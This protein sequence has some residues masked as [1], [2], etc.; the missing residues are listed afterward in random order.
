MEELPLEMESGRLRATKNGTDDPA[1]LT[2][3]DGASVLHPMATLGDV[4]ARP[5]Q[6]ERASRRETIQ[7]NRAGTDHLARSV[8]LSLVVLTLIAVG[9][10]AYWG[11]GRAMTARATYQR[12]TVD[13]Q[14]LEAL[15]SARS[16]GR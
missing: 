6:P 14:A 7:K 15:R 1:M 2:D 9:S 8:A 12:I 3:E 10:V 11:Y 13:V 4:S 16:L 5:P